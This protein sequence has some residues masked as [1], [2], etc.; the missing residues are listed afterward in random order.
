[1]NSGRFLRVEWLPG[2]DQLLGHCHCGAT[3]EGGD[4]AAMWEWLLAHPDHPAGGPAVPIVSQP[5]ARPPAHVI[6]DVTQIDGRVPVLAAGWGA[7]R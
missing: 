4:P 7:Q 5:P 1:M 3:A 6:T 2:S